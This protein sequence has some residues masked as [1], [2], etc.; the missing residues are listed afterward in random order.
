MTNKIQFADK[1]NQLSKGNHRKQQG[2]ALLVSLVMIFILSLLGL[3]SMRSSTLET[4]MAANSIEKDITFQAADSA[5][6]IVLQVEQNLANVICSDTPTQ[7]QITN[8]NHD[9]KLETEAEVSY[10]GETV[11][12]GY[13]LDSGFSALRFTATGTSTMTATGT[14]T[15]I[16]QG[17]MILAAKGNGGGC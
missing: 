15:S 14:A 5:S 9:E 6:E 7:T 8:I 3:T 4:R 16:T 1:I 10:G 11:A 13:S 17:V 12:V 2:A